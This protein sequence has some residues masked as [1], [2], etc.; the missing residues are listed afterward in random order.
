MFTGS[1]DWRA[2][3]YRWRQSGT[4]KLP[5]KS[6]ILRK[7]HFDIQTAEGTVKS[8]RKFVYNYLHDDKFVVVHYVGDAKIAVDFAHGRS[9]K[10]FRMF[11]DSSHKVAY[12]KHGEKS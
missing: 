11:C 6:P 10:C 2:D 8:F 1:Q 3:G 7:V 4:T 9:M 12:S 5:S